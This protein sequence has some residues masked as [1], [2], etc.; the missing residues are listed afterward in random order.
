MSVSRSTRGGSSSAGRPTT[1]RRAAQRD[2]A[3]RAGRRRRPRRDL[4]NEQGVPPPVRADPSE[5][6]FT[7]EVQRQRI[8]R[9]GEDHWRWAIEDE[10]RIVGVIS[11]ADVIRESLQLANVGYFVAQE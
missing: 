5:E 8:E 6:F 1:R 2:S 11:L 4:S 3:A 9:V 10:A 7:A